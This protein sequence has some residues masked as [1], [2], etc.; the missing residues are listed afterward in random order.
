[1][2]S[3]FVKLQEPL[4]DILQYKTLLKRG[5]AVLCSNGTVAKDIIIPIA[6]PIDG[7]EGDWT[8]RI[9]IDLWD[10]DSYVL[11]LWEVQVKSWKKP[12][13]LEQLVKKMV[14]NRTEMLEKMEGRF[15]DSSTP[16][17]KKV[18]IL[19]M[20]V[21]TVAGNCTDVDVG[22]IGGEFSFDQSVTS[23]KTNSQESAA[24][25]EEQPDSKKRKL[26]TV[27]APP[28]PAKVVGLHVCGIQNFHVFEPGEKAKIEQLQTAV[29]QMS[30]LRQYWTSFLEVPEEDQRRY[31]K[32]LQPQYHGSK[33]SEDDV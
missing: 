13:N 33:V 14:D 30:L 5:A 4:T 15:D 32:A 1:M 27:P 9:P 3:H 25:T 18:P 11:T 6:L 2:F 17:P 10:P 20:A 8:T 19:Y 12:F 28:A 24:A 22:S 16:P 23:S 31:A 26:D 21:N 29:D 7:E